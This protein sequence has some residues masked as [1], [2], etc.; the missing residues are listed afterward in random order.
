MSTHIPSGSLVAPR[1]NAAEAIYE[2]KNT[3]ALNQSAV[4]LLRQRDLAGIVF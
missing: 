3:P 2:R 1:T 4:S